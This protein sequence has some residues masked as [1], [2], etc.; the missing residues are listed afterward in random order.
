MAIAL[1]TNALTNQKANRTRSPEVT[2]ITLKVGFV[3]YSG[4]L[5]GCINSILYKTFR[6]YEFSQNDTCTKLPD[7]IYQYANPL[8]KMIIS[9]LPTNSGRVVSFIIHAPLVEETI[10]RLCMQ[11][12]LLKKISSGIFDKN[13]VTDKTNKKAA[14]IRVMLTAAAFALAHANRQEEVTDLGFCS[15]TRLGSTFALG[16]LTGTIQ[17]ITGNTAYS[18]LFHAM[19]NVIPGVIN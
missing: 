14:C 9:T 11:E 17:E 2:I 5:L 15:L 18:M 4:Y 6:D 3:S 1:H 10:F 16:L 13:I 8:Q 7:A 12:I 19:W